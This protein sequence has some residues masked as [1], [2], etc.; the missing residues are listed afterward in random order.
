MAIEH[1]SVR[2]GHS[3]DKANIET[4]LSTILK[5]VRNLA[6]HQRVREAKRQNIADQLELL[7]NKAIKE[8]SPEV[9]PK[10][11]QPKEAGKVKL[12]KAR[13]SRNLGAVRTGPGNKEN[14]RPMNRA[15]VGGHPKIPEIAF[16][17]IGI[18][19]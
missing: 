12:G 10:K 8:K 16:L 15:R 5:E 11:E 2:A 4:A 3:A 17:F 14:P 1:S 7:M 9:E 13:D 18:R 6:E 19:K